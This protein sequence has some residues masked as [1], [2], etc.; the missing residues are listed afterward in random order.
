MRRFTIYRFE[1]GV[2]GFVQAEDGRY[3]VVKKP[4]CEV[5][6]TCMT[7]SEVRA[8]IKEAGYPLKRGEDVYSDKV[9]KT[10]YM[11]EPKDLVKIATVKETV[12]L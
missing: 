2:Q 4:V 11:Y 9:S 10:V 7:A 8:A 6:D 5:E 3:D 12:E 1:C